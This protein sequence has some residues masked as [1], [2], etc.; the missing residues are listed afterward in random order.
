MK[1]QGDKL[2]QLRKAKSLS[3]LDVVELTGI[4]QSTLSDIENNKKNPRPATVE[5]LCQGLKVKEEYFYIDDAVLPTELLPNMPEETRK[6]IFSDD[7]VPYIVLSEKAK[8]SGISPK[9]LEKMIELLAGENK[10]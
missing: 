4:S 10:K 6:F 3:M 7:N 5:R 2:R 8:K 9:T 1:F